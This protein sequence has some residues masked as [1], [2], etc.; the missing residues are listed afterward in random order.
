[1]DKNLLNVAGTIAFVFGIILCCT[2]FGIIVGVPLIIGGNKL[3]EISRLNDREIEDSMQTILIWGIVFIFICPIVGILTLICYFTSQ[4]PNILK[5]KS[6][7]NDKY[8]NLE[9]LNQLYKDKV[10][11]KE[12]FEAEKARILNK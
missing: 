3:R 1:M 12:E 9:K 4:Y 8:D 5:S 10:L 11:T 2:L 7:D 6:N